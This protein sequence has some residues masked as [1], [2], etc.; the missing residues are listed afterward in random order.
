MPIHDFRCN[1][2]RFV[3]T[4]LVKW[5]VESHTCPE[6]GKA[7]TRVFLV[8]PKLDWLGMGTQ[9]HVSPEFQAKWDKL[10]RK[11]K[12]KEEKFEAEHGPGQY[13]NRAPGS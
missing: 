3:H 2:C 7:S 1:E 12:A 11:Q 13:Y 10:H 4:E 8:A 9:K 6:C 5:D